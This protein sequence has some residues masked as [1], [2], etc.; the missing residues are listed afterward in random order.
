MAN[1]ASVLPVVTHDDDKIHMR[2]ALENPDRPGTQVTFNYVWNDGRY[3]LEGESDVTGEYSQARQ[4]LFEHAQRMAEQYSAVR[5]DA[6]EELEQAQR[7][8]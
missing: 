6:E 2:L 5:R 3:D 4:E 1:N 8:A 7:A